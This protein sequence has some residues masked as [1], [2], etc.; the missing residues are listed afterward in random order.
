MGQCV[1][2]GKVNDFHQSLDYAIL[3]FRKTSLGPTGYLHLGI[4]GINNDHRPNIVFYR[5]ENLNK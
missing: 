3:V 1:S 4:M 5:I 2:F